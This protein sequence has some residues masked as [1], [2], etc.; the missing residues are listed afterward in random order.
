MADTDNLQG[1]DHAQLQADPIGTAQKFNALLRA[2]RTTQSNSPATIMTT[3]GD[4]ITRD[5]T[6]PVRIGV[7]G[8]NTV[9]R[10]DGTDPSWGKIVNADITDDTI[11]VGKLADGTAGQLITWDAAGEATTVATGNSGQVLTSNGAGAAPTMQ[12]PTI[13][14][15]SVLTTDDVLDGSADFVPYRDTGEGANNKAT[16]RRLSATGFLEQQTASSSATIDFALDSY[17]EYRHFLVVMEHVIPATDTQDLWALFSTD[18]G[19]TFANSAG[20]YSYAGLGETTAAFITNVSASAAQIELNGSADQLGNQAN[21]YYNARVW[22]TLP[23]ST[24]QR[25]TIRCEAEYSSAVTARLT[26]FT[27]TGNRLNAEDITDI[28]FRMASG[29]ITSGTFTLYGLRG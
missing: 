24:A 16:L 7:G 11:A 28:R 2:Q 27:S 22:I 1:L 26:V 19:S 6:G 21:E 5:A 20:N 13:G 29:N 12:A 4:L 9:L 17:T 10:S 25:P 23:N 14:D 15:I 18:G 3:R 8:A